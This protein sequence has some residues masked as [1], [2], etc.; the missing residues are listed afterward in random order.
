MVRLVLPWKTESKTAL[1]TGHFPAYNSKNEKT[2]RCS[3]LCFLGG[4][5]SKGERHVFVKGHWDARYLSRWDTTDSGL[6]VKNTSPQATQMTYI[7]QRSS[8]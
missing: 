4:E 7:L 6:K 3:F 2:A 5:R 1:K 8:N